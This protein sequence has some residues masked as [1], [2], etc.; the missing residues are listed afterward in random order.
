[1]DQIEQTT[2]LV[3]TADQARMYNLL[4]PTTDESL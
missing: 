1:M 3:V 2:T 4:H